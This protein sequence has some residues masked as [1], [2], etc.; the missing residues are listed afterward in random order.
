MSK[1]K[2]A[3][4]IAKHF[5]SGQTYGGKDYFKLH[6]CGVVRSLKQHSLPVEY[7]I[8]G[9]LHDVV[10]DTPVETASIV[11]LF[12]KTVGE[13]VDAITKRDGESRKEYLQR[14]KSNKIARIVKLHDAL[15]N[16]TSCHKN[17]NKNKHNYYVQTIAALEADINV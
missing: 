15:Y 8:V 9:F 7:L 12:G 3:K 2:L 16:A 13:A 14:C 1:L 17:K 5:H 4:T 11:N 6:V 10:E